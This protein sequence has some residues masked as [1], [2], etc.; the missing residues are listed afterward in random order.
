MLNLGKEYKSGMNFH[1]R[2]F[3]FFRNPLSGK[4]YLFLNDSFVRTLF[5]TS[6]SGNAGEYRLTKYIES[7]DINSYFIT[8][9]N[10][11]NTYLVFTEENDQSINITSLE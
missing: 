2:F 8:N 1:K 10:F 3:R 5:N 11:K 9:F 4:S 7:I 6:V